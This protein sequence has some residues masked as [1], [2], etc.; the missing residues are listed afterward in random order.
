[1]VFLFLLRSLRGRT[2][3]KSAAWAGV[4]LGVSW[5]CGHH[6]PAFILTL[7]VIGTGAAA[8]VQSAD[9]KAVALRLAVLFGVMALVSAV[10]VLP[11]MEY[12]KQAKRWTATGALT[13]KMKV[14]IPEHEDSGLPPPT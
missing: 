14:G 2:P 12:G 5:L 7:A 9:R 1:M 10:Q 13:W 4:V 6:E 8:L 11:A 3:L